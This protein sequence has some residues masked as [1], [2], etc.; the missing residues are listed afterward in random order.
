MPIP[1]L[2][3]ALSPTMT[4]GK[5]AKWHV[6]VGDVVKAGQV[7]CEIETDKATMEVEA[8]D[9]G[10]VA[11]ILVRGGHRRRGGQHADLRPRRR[12]RERRR[13][14]QV[15]AE[16]RRQRP[17]RRPKRRRRCAPS[18]AAAAGAPRLRRCASAGRR[19]RMEGQDRPHD[20]ARGAARRH[21]RGDAPGRP[22]LPDG[23]GGRAVPGR[24]QDQPGP[25]RGVRRR[26]GSSTRRSPSTA[27]PASASAPRSAA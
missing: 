22:G 24:L 18:R 11:Q 16:P 23:R 12:R 3:P 10:T 20:R 8:V 15:G 21:G 27:S 13:R 6:K 26:S 2:M 7:I 17:R 19:A 25:A 9:E 14:R 5:L 1:V 4:E